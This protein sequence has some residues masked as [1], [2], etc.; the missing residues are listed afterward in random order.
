MLL[1]GLF[2]GI[3]FG[4]LLQKG[5]VAKH[6]VIVN[7]FLIKDMTAVKIMA[8][9]AAVGAVGFYTFANFGLVDAQIKD[10]QLGG[11]I[12][13]GIFFGVGIVLFGYCPGT[14][15][16]AMGEGHKDAFVGVLG[17][18][19]GALL[20][21]V[22]FPFIKQLRNNFPTLGKATLSSFLNISPWI[23]VTVFALIVFVL[24]TMDKTKNKRIVYE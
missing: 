2:T 22:T 16:A 3:I 19:A 14:G 9:A 15:V 1:L 23:L 7:A 18:L 21:V 8:T 10:A 17:M 5:R 13:G 6:D 4:F 11:I 20:Y 24:A 12:A